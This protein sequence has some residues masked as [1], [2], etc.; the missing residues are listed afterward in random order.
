[1]WNNVSWAA[2]VQ[3]NW[4]VNRRLTLNLGLRWDGVPHTYEANNR[5]GNFY[6]V[7]STTRRRAPP[8]LLFDGNHQLRPVPG[9]GTSPNPILA[10]VP[11]YLNGIG[12]PGKNGIPEGLVNNH[13][14]AFGPRLGFAYD[15]TG[16]GKTVVRGGFGIM[17]E[18]IQGND[19]YNAGP[20][21]PFSSN[22]NFNNVSLDNPS[23]FLVNGQT[24]VAP[25]TVASITGLAVD[26]YKL[27]RA[28]QYSI[29]VQ[30]S[31]ASRTV[32]AVMYVGNQSRQQNY[33]QDI[34]LPDP[35]QL[36]GIIGHTVQRNNVNPY[37]GFGSITCLPTE[38]KLITTA[39]RWTS[40][41]RSSRT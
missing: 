27:P 4:R 24:A 13:W 31:L 3:D 2:Y 32:L 22:V 30:H 12:I 35:S 20:N 33:Y 17:Y 36:P 16:T 28:Y 34:N 8:I 11:L 1:M 39:S 19:M 10:G 40:I 15:L 18:R 5:M 37:Q 7:R 26:Q 21:I 6:P 29:G 41:R 14:A 25:I 9:L 38:P 23:T